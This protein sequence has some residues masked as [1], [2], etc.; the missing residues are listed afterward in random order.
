MRLYTVLEQIIRKKS[1][2]RKC[3]PLACERKKSNL[4]LDDLDLMSPRSCPICLNEFI[5]NEQTTQHATTS[6]VNLASKLGF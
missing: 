2:S 1:T 3:P 5:E 6:S 4:V